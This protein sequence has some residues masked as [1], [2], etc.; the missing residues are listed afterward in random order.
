MSYHTEDYDE[1]AELIEYIWHNYLHLLTDL[2]LLANRSIYAEKKAQQTSGVIA[3]LLLEKWGNLDN[4]L[5]IVA[6][7]D[8]PDEFRRRVC[9][10]ILTN[11][12]NKIYINR[13]PNCERV[14]NTPKARQCFWCS[15]DWHEKKSR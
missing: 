7:K 15:H 12:A 13:C 6:L 14:A 11:S 10:R 3:K 8:G 1:D 4:P 2:E 5:V 9:E